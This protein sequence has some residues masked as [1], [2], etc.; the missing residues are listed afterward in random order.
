MAYLQTAS[1]AYYRILQK[2]IDD[3][4]DSREY[5]AERLFPA[6][7]VLLITLLHQDSS[8][9]TVMMTLL[10][11]L[12]LWYRMAKVWSRTPTRTHWKGVKWH[13]CS[14]RVKAIHEGLEGGGF[15]LIFR[16]TACT[17]C[18]SSKFF[19]NTMRGVMCSDR[20]S[21]SMPTLE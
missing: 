15:L 7:H 4:T 6:R 16:Q 18:F 13:T 10:Q 3:I 19:S 12:E 17:K 11:R 2:T 20:L 1:G 9:H 21:N 5:P 8:F 14:G